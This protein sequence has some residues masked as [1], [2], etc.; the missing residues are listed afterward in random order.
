M[1]DVSITAALVAVI[2]ALSK[3][4]EWATSKYGAGTKV[5][6]N[7]EVLRQIRETYEKTATNNM[8]I[9]K[10]L[11]EMKHHNE[12]MSDAL[13]EVARCLEK[14]ADSQSKTVE[15]LEKIVKSQEI[16]AAVS[17]ELRRR[18]VNGGSQ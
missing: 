16:E 9:E 1:A 13:S 17:A 3:L 2:I 15:T 12:K 5:A 7:P 11:S 8:I 14:V 18:G 6:L 10:E 4:I